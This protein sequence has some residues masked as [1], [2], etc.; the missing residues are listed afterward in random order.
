MQ[1]IAGVQFQPG[2]EMRL[3]LELAE[4]DAS[5][6]DPQIFSPLPQPPAGSKRFERAPDPAQR[7]LLRVYRA[8]ARNFRVGENRVE[9]R[10]LDRRPYAPGADIQVEK[11][12]VD[13]EYRP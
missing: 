9:I 6:K 2:E 8:P 5:W 12:E 4:Q 13:A 10:V 1:V 11:I 7:L 3:A